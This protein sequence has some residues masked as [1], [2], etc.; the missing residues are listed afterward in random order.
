MIGVVALGRRNRNRLTGLLFYF[1]ENFIRCAPK[2]LPLG[3][4]ESI[5]RFI[6]LA[7]SANKEL[8]KPEIA[9]EFLLDSQHVHVEPDLGN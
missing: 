4:N 6:R 5:M 2:T 7:G 1:F 8:V 3:A 9:A